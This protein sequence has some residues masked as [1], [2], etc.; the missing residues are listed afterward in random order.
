[1]KNGR[2]YIFGYGSLINSISRNRTCSCVPSYEASVSGFKRG[3]YYRDLLRDMTEVGVVLDE[4]AICNGVLFEVL[5]DNFR[6]LD[7]REV[8]Y[9]RVLVPFN[10][11]D[12]KD[13]NCKLGE[14]DRVW[15]YILKEPIFP[16]V[17]FPIAQ[18]YIDIIITGCL[19]FSEKMAREFIRSTCAWDYVWVDNR[20]GGKKEN[21]KLVDD[22]LRDEL[23]L[24]FNSRITKGTLD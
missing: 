22:I 19:D 5:E 15:I 4:K 11:V 23:G 6:F 8:G 24:R 9:D 13:T 10:R 17:G 20:C 18:S 21:H 2:D 1:M 7:E 3:W 14:N 12:C 16:S